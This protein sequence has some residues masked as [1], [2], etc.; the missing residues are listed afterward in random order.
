[1]T[2]PEPFDPAK[3]RRAVLRL[4][5]A[6]F[7]GVALIVLLAID[8]FGYEQVR[9]IWDEAT[10]YVTLIKWTG[11]TILIYRWEE[12]IDWAAER[13]RFGKGYRDYLVAI[14]WRVAAAIVI[15]E[16]LFG[17]NLLG[18]INLL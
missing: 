18:R 4:S 9:E 16:L 7:S 5:I 10:P 8:L 2:A 14:R 11:L 13:W 17:Q 6:L 12:F 1:M 3:A 15:L